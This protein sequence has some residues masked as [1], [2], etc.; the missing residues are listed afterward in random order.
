MQEKVKII[1]NHIVHI[2]TI[3]DKNTQ[4]RILWDVETYRTFPSEDLS[5][6]VRNESLV[7]ELNSAIRKEVN[8]NIMV[9]KGTE[10]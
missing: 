5:F 9:A 6:Q 3:L 7:S 8:G 1:T 2:W 10:V 4:K